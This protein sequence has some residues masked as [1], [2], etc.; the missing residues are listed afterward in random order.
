VLNSEQL[1]TFAS[2]PN[3]VLSRDLK[4][5]PQAVESGWKKESSHPEK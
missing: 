1:L 3:N 5:S 4:I 2:D